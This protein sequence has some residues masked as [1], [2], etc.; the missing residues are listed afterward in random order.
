MSAPSSLRCRLDAL[1]FEHVGDGAASHLVSQVAER[2]LYTGVTPARILQCHAHDQFSDDAH[3]SRAPRLAPVAEVE[4]AS[5][6]LPAQ[7][8]IRRDDRAQI[9]QNLA[10]NAERL[11]RQQ[12]A[13]LVREAK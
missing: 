9:D 12:R 5:D 3:R 1:K 13:F 7:Q 6:E 10:W 2:A 4:L 11:T 8:R